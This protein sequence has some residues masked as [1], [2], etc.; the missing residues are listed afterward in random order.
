MFC[1][2]KWASKK[3][4]RYHLRKILNTKL[5]HYVHNKFKLNSKIFFIFG[6]YCLYSII[7]IIISFVCHSPLAFSNT[8]FTKRTNAFT[9]YKKI[10]LW[11]SV[12]RAS[13]SKEWWRLLALAWRTEAK[14]LAWKKKAKSLI[15]IVSYC[16]YLLIIMYWPCSIGRKG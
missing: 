9:V 1:S 6:C 3:R 13:F 14:Y 11:K 5:F 10:F 12:N 15:M 8:F 2:I 16:F 4:R 7:Q